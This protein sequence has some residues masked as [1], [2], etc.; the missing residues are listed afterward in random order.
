MAVER[1][2]RRGMSTIDVVEVQFDV[3][4]MNERGMSTPG[5]LNVMLSG[6]TVVCDLPDTKS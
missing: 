2:Y 6:L 5:A 4:Y 1:Q 3:A